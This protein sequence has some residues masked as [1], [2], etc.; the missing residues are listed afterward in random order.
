VKVLIKYPNI[1]LSITYIDYDNPR[2]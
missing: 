1:K 2:N